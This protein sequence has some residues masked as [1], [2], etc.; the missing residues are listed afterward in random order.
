MIHGLDVVDNFFDVFGRV[1]LAGFVV[2]D[3]FEGALGSLDLGRKDGFVADIHGDEEVGAGEHGA[4]AIESAE[5][6]VGI[7]QQSTDLL[8]LSERRD[9]RKRGRDECGVAFALF[10]KM[11]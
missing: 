10:Y 3:V 5:G 2:D 7:R 1:L 9:W 11:A 6:A 4:D 8:I